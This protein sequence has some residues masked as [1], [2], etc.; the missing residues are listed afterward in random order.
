M[1]FENPSYEEKV[2]SKERVSVHIESK[3]E[4]FVPED[5]KKNPF[6][7]FE[8]YGKN[9][10][11]G[12][13]KKDEEGKIR[14][15]PTAVKELPV[16]VN[17]DGIELKTVG[18]RINFEKGE[19]GESKNPFYEYDVLEII[20]NLGLPCSNPIVKVERDNEYLMIMEK[21]EGV[22]WY[23]RDGLNLKQKG[24]TDEDIE[25]LKNQAE[26]KMTKLKFQFEEAGILRGWKLKDM[27]FDIDIENKIIKSIIPVD[28]ER[29]KIDQQKLDE[30]KNKL[31]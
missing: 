19:V 7:Y 13:V 28:W 29:T 9:I 5:F 26:D 18:K 3:Y 6:V 15:D 1:S 4:S 16:W 24:Y 8:T 10:K 31:K 12:E 14:E 22:G 25:D 23:D 21:V 27:I 11:S 2:E 20:Q 17:N 30:Y